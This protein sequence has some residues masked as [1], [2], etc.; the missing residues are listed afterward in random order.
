MTATPHTSKLTDARERFLASVLD[1]TIASGVRSAADFLRAFP[2]RTIMNA[3]ADQPQLRAKLLIATTG[4]HEKVAEKK[5]PASAGE[6]L[7][8]ALTERITNEDAV[9]SLFDADDRV[10]YLDHGRLWGFVTE[11]QFWKITNASTPQTLARDHVVF[12]L[13]RARA[14]KLVKAREVIDGIGVSEIVAATPHDELAPL[15]EAVLADG[16]A[17]KPF[18]DE[19]ALAVLPLS[20]LLA[21]VSLAHVW[22]RV[23]AKKLSFGAGAAEEPESEQRVSIDL[24]VDEEPH[25]PAAAAPP[26]PPPAAAVDPVLSELIGPKKVRDAASDR[27]TVPSEPL[28]VP[29][30][31]R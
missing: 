11:G 21:H 18:D 17:G 13:E 23:V 19:R 9:V 16:R 31:K 26:P 10:R 25:T 20:R 22:E 27:L 5:S 24:V 30:V 2:P 8:I 4:Q 14:E 12:I 28:A 3:L 1:R 15:F 29:A 7:E 6:D